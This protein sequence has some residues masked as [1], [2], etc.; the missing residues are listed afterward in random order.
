M[1]LKFRDITKGIRIRPLVGDPSDSILG[2]IWYNSTVKRFKTYLESAIRVFVTEDQSQVLTNKTIDKASNTISNLDTTNFASGIIDTDLTIVSLLDDTIPSAKATKTYADSVGGGAATALNNH[3]TNSTGAHASSAISYDHT[4]S[5]LLAV[6][7]KT[8]IDEVTGRLGT[9]EGVANSAYSTANTALSTANLAATAASPSITGTLTH[10]NYVILGGT[11][12]LLA[13]QTSTN[14][15]DLSTY[16]SAKLLVYIATATVFE[17]FD[18]LL[19]KRSFDYKISV[20]ST[21]DN[22]GISFNITNAGMLQYSS[23]SETS[24]IT[25][26]I[27]GL[28]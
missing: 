27:V 14:L 20:S 4:I 18:I 16:K 6:N 2:S 1:S 11:A 9:T 3:I 26:N 23:G 17:S 19:C 25:Y 5:G 21:G 7:V 13:G 24:T 8:A 22:C 12:P 10:S 28:L 15:I